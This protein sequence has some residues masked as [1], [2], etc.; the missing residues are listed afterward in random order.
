[1]KSFEINTCKKGEGGGRNKQQIIG[2]S[3]GKRALRAK[4]MAIA[5]TKSSRRFCGC[6]SDATDNWVVERQKGSS[7]ESHG[8]QELSRV[9]KVITPLLRLQE[10]RNR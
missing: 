8:N 6:K 3:N 1:L 7:R 9:N 4:V 5:L 10:R 2:L